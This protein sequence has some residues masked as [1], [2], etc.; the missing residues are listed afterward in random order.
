MTR[1]LPRLHAITNDEVLALP[2]FLARAR[3]LAAVPSIAVHIRSGSLGGRRLTELAELAQHAPV[4][5]S[6]FVND[7]ADVARIVGAAGLHLPSAGLSVAKARSIVGSACWIGRSAHTADEIVRAAQEG[8]DYVFLGPIWP[9]TSHPNTQPLGPK[10]L[11]VD[12]P[13]PVIAIGG[14]TPEKVPQC[15][16]YGAYGVAVISTLWSAPDVASTAR[17]LSLSFP[18]E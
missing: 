13:I 10:A 12:A 16:E 3:Q 17:A 5:E 15:L 2:D 11:A 4:G 6:I 1:Q 9:T 18:H 7:R 14:I 8:A